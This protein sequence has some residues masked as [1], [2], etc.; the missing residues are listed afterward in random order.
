MLP[1]NTQSDEQDIL[2]GGAFDTTGKGVV[3]NKPVGEYY[4]QNAASIRTPRMGGPMQMPGSPMGTED[5]M[6]EEPMDDEME[7]ESEEAL[8]EHLAALF[9]DSNLSEQFVERAKTI[10]V[11]AVNQKVNERSA[12]LYE[13]YKISFNSALN[14]TVS[15]LTEKVDDYLTYVVEEWV[16]ENRLQVERGVKVEL[17]EN[18]IFGLKKLFETNFIDVPDEKY[19]VLDELYTQIDNQKRHLNKSIHENVSLRKKLIDT[20]AIAV[21]A[22]ET[23][24]LAA[25][26]VDRLANLAE[27]VEF[28]T[29]DEFRRKLRVIK[30]SFLARPAQ[31][32]P[33]VQPRSLPRIQSVNRAIDILE[34]STVPETLTESTVNAYA[35]AISRHL[36]NR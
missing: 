1:Q 23:A 3:L 9:A 13:A 29:A 35:N 2:G 10:F 26:Q 22:E 7:A 28:D 12:K 16:S 15:E 6:E 32:Q 31:I 36:K 30:E 27:G 14:N 24:G 20:A 33:Q 18:F 19:D 4:A 11:A 21:F 8:K 5:G 25:T 34:T 17:A